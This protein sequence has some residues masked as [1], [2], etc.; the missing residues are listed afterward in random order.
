MFPFIRTTS[1]KIGWN[2]V[3]Q[4]LNLNIMTVEGTHRSTGCLTGRQT[5]NKPNNKGKNIQKEMGIFEVYLVL[6]VIY[7]NIIW[8]VRLYI[9]LYTDP[10]FEGLG[11]V[12]PSNATVLP[13]V[14]LIAITIFREWYREM[15]NRDPDCNDKFFW[16]LDDRK[17]GFPTFDEKLVVFLV[18]MDGLPQFWFCHHHEGHGWHKTHK[19]YH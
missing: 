19:P 7:L 5:W 10:C 3:N 14:F 2:D 12:R 18:S 11:Y 15:V 16:L 1:E 13:I 6:A 4:I 17:I 9:N 8:N